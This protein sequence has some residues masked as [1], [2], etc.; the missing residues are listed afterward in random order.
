MQK[1]RRIKNWQRNVAIY[2]HAN[3]WDEL[4]S[5]VYR[6]IGLHNDEFGTAMG[7]RYL[8]IKLNQS[9]EAVRQAVAK[10]NQGPGLIRILDSTQ[11]GSSGG[12]SYGLTLRAN[13]M[14]LAP[15]A[16]RNAY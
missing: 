7:E 11:D 14:N 6:A 2:S 15:I 3:G 1:G 13:V 9:P 12:R 4:Q 8:A 10:I 16:P 5:R